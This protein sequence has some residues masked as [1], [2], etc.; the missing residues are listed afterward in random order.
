MQRSSGWVAGLAAILVG[1]TGCAPAA[2]PQ[3]ASDTPV[4]LPETRITKTDPATLPALFQDASDKL[5]RDQFKEAAADFD[6]IVAVDP[7][8]PTAGPS[9]YN[10]GLAYLGLDERDEALARFRQS[11]DEFPDLPTTRPALLRTSR[12]LSYEER[13]SDLEKIATELLARKDL[14]ILE[15][16]EAMGGKGLA[17]VSQGKVDEAFDV[18]VRARNMI[19]DNHL[20]EA[21]L[22]PIELA[23]VSFALGEIRRIKSE[24][25]VFVPFPENFGAT[26]EDRCTGLLDAQEAY[27]DAMRSKDAHWSA[28]SGY[29][30]GELYAQL[31]ADVM[32]AP[33]PAAKTAKLQQLYEGAV[34]LRYRIL[35]EKGLTMMDH[36]VALGDRTGE[37]SEW[38]HRAREAQKQLQVALADEKEALSKLPYTEDEMREALEMLKGKKK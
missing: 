20:S 23:Q 11:V 33:V 13:W 16:I 4:V 8:G 28:M 15:T 30:V 36:T 2:P 26:L 1:S 18:I 14:T 32:K 27:T 22:P 21:G 17:L 3:T 35:L 25:I 9:L 12:I 31:H 7:T 19:E 6:H 37:S 38:I 34:R 5:L 29:R 10:A 24:K